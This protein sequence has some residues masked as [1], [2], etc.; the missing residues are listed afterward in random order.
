MYNIL[1][2][3]AAGDGIETTA[4]VLQKT[5][6]QMGY[7]VF[8][9]RDFMSRVRGGH[10]FVRIRFGPEPVATHHTALDGIVAINKES[11]ELHKDDLKDDGFIICEPA[12]G[13]DDPHVLPLP[14]GQLA[15][16]AGNAR[17][18]GSV[19][20]GAILSLLGLDLPKAEDVFQG[21]F[22]AHILEAN[23][24]S[25]RSGYEQF[26]ARYEVPAPT[27]LSD[28]AIIDGSHTMALGALAG[29]MRFYS[30]YPMSP[31]T[32][33]LTYFTS[34]QEKAGI[35]V[36]QA[37]DEIA[38]VNM[39]I[40]ASA[41]GAPAM[42]GTSGGGFSL[43][44]EGVGFAGIAEIP[45]VVA[46]IQRP[47]PATGLPTRTEQSDLRFIMHAAQ[48]EFPRMV[49]SPQN[50]RELFQQT[51]RAFAIAEKYQIPVLLLSDQYLAD[52]SAV[53]PLSAFS[54][55]SRYAVKPLDGTVAIEA[56][57][58]NVYKRYQYTDTGISPLLHPGESEYLVRV[59]SDEHT[60]YGVITE[61]AEV[62]LHMVDKRAQKLELLQTELIEP[63][64]FGD[65]S[66]DILLVGFGSTQKAMEEA[67]DLL[68]RE[69][70]PRY[71]MLSF[72]DV[73]PL[74]IQQLTHYAGLADKVLSVEQN[75]T[76]QFAGVVRETTLIDCRPAVLKY[77]GRQMTAK[78][79][80]AQLKT[81]G[82]EGK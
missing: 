47:G 64:F 58:D 42:T 12:L 75:A 8:T 36:E 60:E 61:S 52:S 30:A 65:D 35:V 62:R 26:E 24:A 40:G 17:A 34:I 22:A 54:E 11:Y 70:G 16:D 38:A 23:I 77:D 1:I 73:Y 21:H 37:E 79:I 3:G 20:I 13:I 67:V 53:V 25:L 49:I 80:L 29:N 7:Y 2:G 59:D 51:K 41:G 18:A 44:T 39:A 43:M 6:K 55:D 81:Y 72:G 57:E 68:N 31:A 33:L 19:V 14:F 82:K 63:T 66:P 10:N 28:H 45:L 9:M 46:D 74:P 78:D 5:L 4:A 15:T 50:H 32:T 48:G 27:D 76:G 56:D 69:Q 71:G